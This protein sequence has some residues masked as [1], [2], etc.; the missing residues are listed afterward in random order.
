[1]LDRKLNVLW[2]GRSGGIEDRM[3][4]EMQYGMGNVML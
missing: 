3:Y 1:M 2:T 4:V